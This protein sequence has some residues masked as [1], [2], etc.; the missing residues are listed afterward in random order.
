MSKSQNFEEAAV[1]PETG[2]LIRDVETQVN[3]HVDEYLNGQ[4][5]KMNIVD[6]VPIS[7][8]GRNPVGVNR[9][10]N[11]YI[12]HLV[13]GAR[14][15][16]G[17]DLSFQFPIDPKAENPFNITLKWTD[18][19]QCRLAIVDKRPILLV[20]DGD[21]DMSNILYS[22][23]I[24]PN[25]ME[26][27]RRTLGLPT[28]LWGENFMDLFQDVKSR[29]MHLQRSSKTLVDPFTNME[30]VHD[31]RYMKN[32]DD[33]QELVQ[34]LC[35][36]I[37][38]LDAGTEGGDGEMYLPAGSAYRNMLRFE[39]DE[40]GNQWVYRGAYSGKLVTGEFVDEVVQV[41]PKLG[42]PNEKIIN[43][44]LSTLSQQPY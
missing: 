19:V 15:F 18:G 9:I 41:D 39:R 21:E 34:E 17:I 8:D 24:H 22:A 25:E 31:A 40:S 7:P 13:E 2:H 12:S 4:P 5:F 1:P 35:L 42:I 27:Y 32:D 3:E 33:E 37:D 36:N 6:F 16:C 43:K 28:S 38:H 30:I 11:T 10:H 26:I 23:L 20:E 29:D 44:A 14:E